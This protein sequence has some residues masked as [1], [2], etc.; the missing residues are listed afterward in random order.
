MIKIFLLKKIIL[1]IFLLEG[2]SVF[3][4]FSAVEA[5]EKKNIEVL[6]QGKKNLLT[7]N[8]NIS[9]I[10][11]VESLNVTEFPSELQKHILKIGV[12]NS[13]PFSFLSSEKKWVGLA[14][15]LWETIAQE[16]NLQ[17][18]YVAL[19]ENNIDGMASQDV[20]K[21][22]QPALE[23]K[24]CDIIIWPFPDYVLSGTEKFVYT[25]PYFT[26]TLAALVKSQNKFVIDI[27]LRKIFSPTF[28]NFCFLLFVYLFFGALGFWACERKAQKALKDTSFFKGMG[29]SFWWSSASFSNIGCNDYSPATYKGRIFGFFWFFLCAIAISSFTAEITSLL[30]TERIK[31]SIQSKNDLRHIRV[32]TQEDSLGEIYLRENYISY[33]A[34]ASFEEGV[35]LIEENKADLYFGSDTLLRYYTAHNDLEL[36]VVGDFSTGEYYSFIVQED[37]VFLKAFSQQILKI[38]NSPAW[39]DIL[40]TY[41]GYLSNRHG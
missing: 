7:Q 33:K 4:N 29:H 26:G 23:R 3:W 21:V 39:K 40:Y 13:P 22:V 28:Y 20:V 41:L 6:S 30:T 31:D 25:V 8:K 1:L 38:I 32:L 5:R 36:K 24:K 15:D 10:E 19:L 35:K 14:V 17:F 11:K 37:A 2:L 34:V 9:S 18:E 27:L 16:N 12:F